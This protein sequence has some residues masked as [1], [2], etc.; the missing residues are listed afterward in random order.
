MELSRTFDADLR[1]DGE[2]VAFFGRWN[3]SANDTALFSEF[4][5]W[6]RKIGARRVYGPVESSTLGMY[7]LQISDFESPETFPGEPRNPAALPE[8]LSALGYSIAQTYVTYWTSRISEIR[9]WAETASRGPLGKLSPDFKLREITPEYW[10]GRQE[11]LRVAVNDIFAENFAFTPIDEGTFEAAFGGTFLNV[12]CQRTSFVVEHSSGEIA[13]LCICF[14]GP[15]GTLYVKTVGIVERYRGR[16]ISLV[17]MIL[18]IFARATK[19]VNYR[20]VALCL[21]RE[22]NFP[23]LLLKPLIERE[24]RYALFA[25]ELPEL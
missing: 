12:I 24:R 25:K 14:P 23:S 9:A 20:R 19:G 7:R 2:P 22:G 10:A 15:G 11:D 16:G 4:E 13:G 6:A 21:M 3:P 5:S 17:A 18:E 1:I 8:R